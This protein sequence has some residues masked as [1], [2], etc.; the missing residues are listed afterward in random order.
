[1]TPLE[2]N[3]AGRPVIAFRAGGATETV[4]DRTTGVFFDEPTAESLAE[5]IG[6]FETVTWDPEA[7]RKHA[8]GFGRGVFAASIIDLITSIVP[9]YATR[10]IGEETRS[11]ALSPPSGRPVLS[12]VVNEPVLLGNTAD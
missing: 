4:I 9:S 3:A 1:M 12:Q 8:Q 10:S 6:S 5:A 2:V 7:I 11:H